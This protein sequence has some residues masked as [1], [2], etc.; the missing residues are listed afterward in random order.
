VS[1]QILTPR[2]IIPGSFTGYQRSAHL[3]IPHDSYIFATQAEVM[4]DE[5][6]R[7]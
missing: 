4:L 3:S 7:S 5:S 6:T 1:I 2:K